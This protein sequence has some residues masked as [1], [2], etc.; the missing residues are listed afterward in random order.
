L[1]IGVPN[2]HLSAINACGSC[3]IYLTAAGVT[4]V[5]NDHSCNSEKVTGEDVLCLVQ[6]VT[7]AYVWSGDVAPRLWVEVSGSVRASAVLTLVKWSRYPLTERPSGHSEQGSS[8][9]SRMLGK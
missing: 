2:A 5:L 9:S 7:K 6:L 8:S 4:N 3:R 1:V